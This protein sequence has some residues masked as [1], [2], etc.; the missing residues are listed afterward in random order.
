M[1]SIRELNETGGPVAGTT[2][3]SV[4]I[5]SGCTVPTLG[6]DPFVGCIAGCH[7]GLKSR[8]LLASFWSGLISLVMLV[9]FRKVAGREVE[10][11]F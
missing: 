5:F 10:L 7:F 1:E 3:Y 11:E 8:V 4:I 9:I 2:A 6:I